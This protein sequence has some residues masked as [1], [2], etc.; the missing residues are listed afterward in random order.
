MLAP[1]LAPST[2]VSAEA[3]GLARQLRDRVRVIDLRFDAALSTVTAPLRARLR[4][5]IRLRHEQVKIAALAYRRD[6]P[7]EFR[8]GDVTIIPDRDRFAISEVR[9]TATVQKGAVWEDDDVEPGIAVCHWALKLTRGKLKSSWTPAAIV[10]GHGIARRIER[11]IGRDQ[12]ALV[13]DLA[14]LAQAGEDGDEVA[15]ADGWWRGSVVPMRGEAGIVQVRAVR[16]FY[17]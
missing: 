10:S 15:T 5:H 17:T 6:M 7:S 14:L 9:L 16:S 3:R 13:R 4:H 1:A 11:G 8:L 2:R 12:D